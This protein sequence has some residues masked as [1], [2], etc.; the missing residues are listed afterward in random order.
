MSGRHEGKACEA[1][2]AEFWSAYPS[3]TAKPKAREAYRKVAGEHHAIMA[4]LRLYIET[5]PVDR[6]WL[7]P[8]TFLN[9]RRWEDVAPERPFY[10]PP[11]E[12]R[13]SCFETSKPPLRF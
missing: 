6:A 4:G 11:A 10:A 8:T 13:A 12:R 2:F 3:K 9:Q 1:E 7:H 5:K